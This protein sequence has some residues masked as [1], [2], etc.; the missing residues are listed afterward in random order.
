MAQSFFRV[1]WLWALDS[2]GGGWQVDPRG[3]RDRRAGTCL[4]WLLAYLLTLVPR[5]REMG[6]STSS[7][8]SGHAPNS[9]PREKFAYVVQSQGPK[10]MLCGHRL[11][12]VLALPLLGPGPARRACLHI[13]PSPA[14]PDCTPSTRVGAQAGPRGG[15]TLP[16]LGGPSCEAGQESVDRDPVAG[17]H[18]SDHWALRVWFCTCSQHPLES[19]CCG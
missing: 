5:S 14:G 9:G 12:E 2:K 17:Q 6:G 3:C 4:T 10:G 11:A 7:P 13:R 8:G 19:S 15:G 16:M 1:L 18:G